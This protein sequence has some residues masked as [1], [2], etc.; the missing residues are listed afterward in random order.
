MS[1]VKKLQIQGMRR[2]DWR[3]AGSS[4]KTRP[5]DRRP[6]RLAKVNVFARWW[7][8]E[9][10]LPSY[11]IT[12]EQER[13]PP[14]VYGLK[15]E[16]G[17]TVVR[18][19]DTAGIPDYDVVSTTDLFAEASP[20][21][22]LWFR[23]A[24]RLFVIVDPAV[25][26]IY[27]DTIK[28]YLE[29]CG[30]PFAVYALPKLANNE[31]NKSV[32]S[33][34]KLHTWLMEHQ[35]GPTDLL[36]GVGG[37]VVSD[38]VGYTAATTRRGIPYLL[39][40]TTL[41]ATVD[42]GI[43][44]KTGINVGRYKNS[45]GSV[46]PPQCVF[47]D[48]SFLK[49]DPSMKTGMAELIKLSI[50]RSERL[51]RLLEHKGAELLDSRFQSTTGRRVIE[52]GARLFLKMKFELP[53]PGNLPAS[54]R[55][56]GHAFSR[57]LE[58]L[59]RFALTHGEAVG[60]EMAVAATLAYQLGNLSKA[61]RDRIVR[62]LEQLRLLPYCPEC[63]VE[64]VWSVFERRVEADEALWF[65]IPGREIGQGKFLTCFSKTELASAINGVPQIKAR[66]SISG[67]V[68][69]LTRIGDSYPPTHVMADFFDDGSSSFHEQ[70]LGDM[71]WYPS[72]NISLEEDAFAYRLLQD[73]T[74]G[75]S[76]IFQRLLFAE[77]AD[78]AVIRP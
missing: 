10:R 28:A 71:H 77:P 64:E 49:T 19:V 17:N 23:G 5:D 57:H 3:R 20:T 30:V 61:Q 48:V 22:S 11:P 78:I 38:L 34:T 70:E 46:F 4:S 21:L 36:L 69:Y 58:T 51:L 59:S 13:V 50:V 53:F 24:R 33:W 76:R 12:T 32:E 18:V 9:G 27:G 42:A 45:C 39:V 26:E 35:I 1:H 31:E 2:K 41:T 73:N 67:R 54:L 25:C 7:A 29:Q 6:P 43:S 44:P 55:S 62:L 72:E 52:L 60:I 14:G 74:S 40:T 15:D 37:G 47:S 63:N 56:F 75:A 68:E 16:A 8:A 66:E 65:P